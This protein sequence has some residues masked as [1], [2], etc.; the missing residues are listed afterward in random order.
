MFL[1][2]ARHFTIRTDSL[3]KQIG[4]FPHALLLCVKLNVHV[5]PA[6]TQ[7]DMQDVMRTHGLVD[8]IEHNAG[9]QHNFG[10]DRRSKS[11]TPSG[12]AKA[13]T[14]EP[15]E[16]DQFTLSAQSPRFSLNT[17]GPSR[18]TTLCRP[19]DKTLRRVIH[20]HLQKLPEQPPPTIRNH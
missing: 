15:S 18:F 8:S 14:A 6:T 4:H 5:A 11:T 12:L 9:C 13:Q 3:R 10:T 7:R 16:R 1:N 2:R 19:R 17:S 20:D